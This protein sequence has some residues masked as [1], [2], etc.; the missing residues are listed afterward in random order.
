MTSDLPSLLL[1]AH[2]GVTWYMTG[3]IWFV[4]CVHYPLFRLVGPE[5]FAAYERQHTRRTGWVVAP[6]MLLELGLAGALLGIHGGWLAGGGFALL[7]VIWASTFF[8]QVPLHRKLERGFDATIVDRLVTT[9]WIRTL[10]WT[11]RSLLALAM[12][13]I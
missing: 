12:L 3:V 4:Q 2:A 9:N 10:A 8:L 11:V 7:I 1:Y 6:P 13:R 5:G